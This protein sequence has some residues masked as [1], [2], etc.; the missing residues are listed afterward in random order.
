M[1]TGPESERDRDKR[2]R[3]QDDE[4]KS[5]GFG[6]SGHWERPGSPP[7]PPEASSPS[8]TLTQAHRDPFWTSAFQNLPEAVRLC[9]LKPRSLDCLSQWPQEL[10]VAR[11]SASARVRGPHGGGGEGVCGGGGAGESRRGPGEWCVVGVEHCAAGCRPRRRRTSGAQ[12]T[13]GRGAPVL[14]R[15]TRRRSGHD[16]G[17]ARCT[18]RTPGGRPC[19]RHSRVGV[20]ETCLCPRKP[21]LSWSDSVAPGCP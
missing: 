19:T 21:S 5:R 17:S 14:S 18:L 3:S 20:A 10:N 9:C 12:S 7:E 2:G 4:A 1:H 6:P 16:N 8:C 11:G 15:R 13:V